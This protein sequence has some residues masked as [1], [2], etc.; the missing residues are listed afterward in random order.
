MKAAA[1]AYKGAPMEGMV[2]S[3]YA[4]STAR[5]M[6]AYTSDA[7]RAAALLTPGARVLEVAP[8]PGYFGIELARMGDF[9]ITGLDIS[10]SFVEMAQ[11]NAARAGVRVEFRLGSAS[12]IPFQNGQF[13][14]LFCRAAFKNFS[15]PQRALQEMCRVLRPGGRAWIIDLRRNASL[16]S[17]NQEVARM[18]LGLFSAWLT[19]LAFRYS[20]LKRAYNKPEFER[21]LAQTEFGHF[22]VEEQGIGL[23]IWLTK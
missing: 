22:M 15:E 5:S 23:D 11:G 14:F 17:I 19:R 3:W 9:D 12:E 20:L 1:K 16:A 13:D 18:G 4:K 7:R 21:L 8:G 6:S 10:R 2:A